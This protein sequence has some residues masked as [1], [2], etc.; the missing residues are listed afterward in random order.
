MIYKT[1]EEI[2]E[3]GKAV[4]KRMIDSGVLEVNDGKYI[5]LSED[6]VKIFIILGRLGLI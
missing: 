4:V 1:I 3:S 6:M 5:N 2:P